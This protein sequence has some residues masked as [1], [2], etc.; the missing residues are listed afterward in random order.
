LKKDSITNYFDLGMKKLD[1]ISL[2]DTIGR[3]LQ[4]R[5]TF[6]KIHELKISIIGIK[7]EIWRLI[8]VDSNISLN[9]LHHVIQISMGWT[10]SHLYSFRIDEIEYSLPEINKEYIT[11]VYS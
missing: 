9:E 1:K 6:S 2:I 5:M 7:P 8:Q 10:N 4:S 3:E 11:N